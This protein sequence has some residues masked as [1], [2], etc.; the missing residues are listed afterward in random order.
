MISLENPANSLAH[1][2]SLL[3]SL[4]LASS[5]FSPLH[6]P[7][8]PRE[9]FTLLKASAYST[10]VPMATISLIS[11]P[12]ALSPVPFLPLTAHCS[13]LTELFPWPD[14]APAHFII[15]ML[16]A[17]RSYRNAKKTTTSPF[18]PQI[19]NSKFTIR[20]CLPMPHALC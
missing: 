20:N 7:C 12:S 15:Q 14:H 4:P 19:H 9:I 5:I 11:M 2:E 6:A 1:C 18:F 8:A 16:C 10:R 3:F 13:P 17:W